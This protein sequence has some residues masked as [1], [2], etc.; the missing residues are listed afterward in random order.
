MSV[1]FHDG[2]RTRVAMVANP[3]MSSR[4]MASAHSPSDS[5]HARPVRASMFAAPIVAFVVK[6][7]KNCD[8][9]TDAWSAAQRR[10]AHAAA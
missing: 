9:I 7:R 5:S 2:N 10:N 6:S 1:R 4:Y 8:S 3:G